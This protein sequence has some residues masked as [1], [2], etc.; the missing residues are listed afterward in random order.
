VLEEQRGIAAMSFQLPDPIVDVLLDKL[1]NDD[2]FRTQFASD[3]RSAL[4][5]LGF[6]AAADTSIQRGVWNCMEVNQLASK[7]A[8]RAGHDELR[9][10][11]RRT[12]VFFPF[13][14]QDAAVPLK[15]VA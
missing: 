9:D 5:G 3:P 11:L 7:E 12:A 13:N 14:I 10:Q 6:A 2:A 1:G 4:A 15:R 8:I